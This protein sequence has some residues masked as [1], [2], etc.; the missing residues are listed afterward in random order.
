MENSEP[1]VKVNPNMSK[2]EDEKCVKR[3]RPVRVARRIIKGDPA[4][5]QNPV[6]PIVMPGSHATEQ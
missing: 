6:L 3:M 2:N 5:E 1:S 4:G